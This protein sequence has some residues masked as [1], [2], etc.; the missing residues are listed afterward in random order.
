VVVVADHLAVEAVAEEV[1]HP[2]VP[3]V[4]L[5]GVGAVQ[6]LHAG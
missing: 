3:L 4:E 5:L 1:P 6:E 2:A